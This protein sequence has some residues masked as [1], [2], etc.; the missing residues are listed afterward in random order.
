MRNAFLQ[1]LLDVAANDPNVW[2]ITAD[3]GFSVLEPFADRFPERFINVGVAEQNMMGIAAG[4]ALSGKRVVAY[5]I[6]N[7][8]T[9]RCLEQIRNDVV[10]HQADVKIVG[11]GTGYA[12]G[13]QGHTHYGLSDA[14]VMNA[15]GGIGV[16]TPADPIEARYVT[17]VMFE[18]SMP[19]YLRLGRSGEKNL[20]SS[21]PEVERGRKIVCRQGSAAL[22][23]ATGNILDEALQ[24]ASILD[25]L[26]HAC[27]VWSMPWISPLDGESIGEAAEKFPVILA[28]EEGTSVGGLGSAV[29]SILA[30]IKSPRARLIIASSGT[31]T[32]SASVW[33]AAAREAEGIDGK[34]IAYRIQNALQD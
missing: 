25:S 13:S 29:A 6:V 24:A 34:S 16:I 21:T 1:G 12:Y 28:L 5:S 2:L 18:S 9:L 20:H 10:H 15:I 33:Q 14:A 11:V 17:R 4:L 23:I 3:L 32:V 30:T 7:F 8:A 31:T 27:A 19:A 22:I 26:G